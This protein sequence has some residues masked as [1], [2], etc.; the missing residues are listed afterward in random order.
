[1]TTSSANTH[2]RSFFSTNYK[3]FRK[4]AVPGV[5][6]KGQTFNSNPNTIS[7]ITYDN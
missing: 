5:M 6:T 3:S 7:D 4:Y 1:M 2:L